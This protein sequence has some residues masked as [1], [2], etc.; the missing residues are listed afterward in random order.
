MEIHEI[1]R[2]TAKRGR[3]GEM[4]DKLKSLKPNT[5]QCVVLKE[6]K[7]SG[8]YSAAKAANLHVSIHKLDGE[9]AG[10]V[11]VYSNGPRTS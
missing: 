3:K 8:A 2:P 1:K 11:G 10:Y 5:D 4:G 9:Y 7:T 6:N